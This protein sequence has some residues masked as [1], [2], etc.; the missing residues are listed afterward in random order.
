MGYPEEIT[1]KSEPLSKS[2]CQAGE[3]TPESDSQ[4]SK[5][6][7]G[8]FQPLVLIGGT[9]G[10]ALCV[11]ALGTYW[12]WGLGSDHRGIWAKV[13]V[14]NRSTQ[15]ITIGATII[16]SCVGL[17]TAFACMILAVLTIYHKQVIFG[18]DAATVS[19]YQVT[20]TG[21][22]SLLVPLWRGWTGGKSPWGFIC[23]VLLLIVSFIVQF[24]S[25]ILVADLYPGSVYGPLQERKR[26][27][28]APDQPDGD[29]QYALRTKP[30]GMP[31]F[32]ECAG[33]NTFKLK[34]SS[35]FKDTKSK[36]RAFIPMDKGEREEVAEYHGP[37]NG[38]DA[39]VICLAIEDVPDLAVFVNV[40]DT[41]INIDQMHLSGTI[42]LPKFVLDS[43]P[44]RPR[45]VLD[46]DL[47]RNLNVSCNITQG[48]FSI[49]PVNLLDD[50]EY[51][52][53][54]ENP[55]KQS[56]V[57][58][59]PS[60]RIDDPTNSW[61]L[62]SRVSWP[63]V[64]NLTEIRQ[65][66]KSISDQNKAITNGSEWATWEAT[67]GRTTI[68]VEQS[69]CLSSFKARYLY[70]EATRAGN[71]T[72]PDLKI[73]K[74]S[75]SGYNAD[76][77]QKLLGTKPSPKGKRGAFEIKKW[78]LIDSTGL[79]NSSLDSS[80]T[81]IETWRE[82]LA[83]NW[84]LSTC[85]AENC[86]GTDG[87][88]YALQAIFNDTLTQSENLALAL[89][90][91]LT[92]VTSINYYDQIAFFDLQAPAHFTRAVTHAIPRKFAGLA[93]VII[94]L[95]LHFVLL[96]AL[97]V[98]FIS[99]RPEKTKH[100]TPYFGNKDRM[101]DV[102]KVLANL[103]RQKDWEEGAQ[104]VENIEGGDQVDLTHK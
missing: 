71:F 67:S 24:T 78:S 46:A 92:V 43:D 89:Q 4:P 82:V 85:L 13:V 98:V 51:G 14:M 12:A 96:I 86:Q 70:I 40:S 73:N 45:N 18:P 103:T 75:I 79:E 83:A 77:I 91:L 23:V 42:K 53:L 28:Y 104:I 64:G 19:M 36:I 94:A 2:G 90:S 76:N 17:Q 88:N 62:I 27:G 56:F 100:A 34:S 44:S 99:I 11:A 31:A 20:S 84:M 52:K 10:I 35:N 87:F 65:A 33:K 63:L 1:P 95:G 60:P 80:I 29:Y 7:F 54:K 25:T 5:S 30:P 38:V 16:R 101:W 22:Q 50:T 57:T 21:P 32:A 48:A 74:G 61:T 102:A 49:C 66:G 59:F 72:E 6:R 26:Q 55:L 39:H 3:T 97:L 58:E 68:K 69:L 41:P 15:I 9:L 8:W 93:V 81:A 37:A 47:S